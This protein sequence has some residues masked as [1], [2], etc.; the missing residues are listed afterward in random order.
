MLNPAYFKRFAIA[1]LIPL[2]IPLIAKA[3]LYFSLLSLITANIMQALSHQIYQKFNIF[4]PSIAVQ[5]LSMMFWP[6][7]GTCLVDLIYRFGFKKAFK[8]Q[9]ICAILLWLLFNSGSFLVR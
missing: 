5:V 1:C 8:Q 4:L 7:I 9:V 2:S 3:L 6:I